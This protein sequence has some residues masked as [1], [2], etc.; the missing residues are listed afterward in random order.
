MI[1]VYSKPGCKPCKM[2]KAKLNQ[3][4]VKYV[5]RDV[6]WDANAFA[7]VEALGYREMPVVVNGEQHW[8]GFRPDLIA[9]LEVGQ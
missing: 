6:T 7:N 1:T 3:M 8:S 4:G 9:A 5:E 2:T